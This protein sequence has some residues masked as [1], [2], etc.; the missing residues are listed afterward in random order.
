MYFLT[1][2]KI[3]VKED[4]Y[5]LQSYLLKLKNKRHSII[6][7]VKQFMFNSQQYTRYLKKYYI[8]ERRKAIHNM[9][10]QVR[11]NLTTII[12]ENQERM[13]SSRK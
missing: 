8:Q 6:N 12:D 13:R 11:I 3:S 4:Y 7:I 9:R 1:L 10:P 2:N 5:I